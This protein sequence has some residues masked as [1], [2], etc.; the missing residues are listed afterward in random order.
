MEEGSALP[1]VMNM[2]TGTTGVHAGAANQKAASTVSL[3]SDLG[4]WK[5][6][7]LDRAETLKPMEVKV[8]TWTQ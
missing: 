1:M 8:D 7:A 4:L 3:Y 6:H 2:A 5:L